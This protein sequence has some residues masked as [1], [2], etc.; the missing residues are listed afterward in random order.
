MVLNRPTQD[1]TGN[2]VRQVANETQLR[3]ARRWRIVLENVT[4]NYREPASGV[5]GQR[6][7]C[8]AAT[9]VDLYRGYCDVVL[10][11]GTGHSPF[12]A[13]NFKEMVTALRLHRTH[14]GDR[15]L[16]V[17]E[18]VLAESSQRDRHDGDYS[19]VDRK[20]GALLLFLFLPGLV[21]QTC[22]WPV[23]ALFGRPDFF[24]RFI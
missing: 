4:M 2:G 24:D 18:P 21:L 6:L 17:G 23:S 16:V 10:Q 3:S 13:T 8:F 1:W 12:P 15:E 19:R 20:L 7:K 14:K 11:Q 9:R 22:L 5:A